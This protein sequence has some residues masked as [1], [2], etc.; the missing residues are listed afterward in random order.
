ML[1]RSFATA[2][3][4]QL[5]VNPVIVPTPG[6]GQERIRYRYLPAIRK[7]RP[8]HATKI[9]QAKNTGLRFFHIKREIHVFWIAQQI[10]A[11]S[12]DNLS[13]RPSC[14]SGKEVKRKSESADLCPGAGECCAGTGVSSIP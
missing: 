1:Q 13:R 11:R 3:L 7:S 14:D 12:N 2:L 10:E 6:I 8:E 4:R 9:R 5:A